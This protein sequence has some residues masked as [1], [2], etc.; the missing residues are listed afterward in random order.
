[1]TMFHDLANAFPLITGEAFDELVEDIKTRGL[2]DPIVM[3]EGKILDGRNRWRASQHLGIPHTEVKLEDLMKK[4]GKDVDP[5]AFVWSRNA[6]RRQLSPSQRA[7]A[8]TKLLDA[9]RGGVRTDDET[10]AERAAAIAGVGKRSVL[11]AKRVVEKGVPAVVEAV[12]AGDLTLEPAEVIAA[13][14]PLTQERIMA[15]GAEEATK[16]VSIERARRKSTPRNPDNGPGRGHVGPKVTMTRQMEGSSAEG[17]KARTAFWAENIE[18]I[19]E[20]DSDL[21]DR[22]VEDLSAERRAI[23]QLLKSIRTARAAEKPAPAA[24]KIT[25]T[26]KSPAAK[27]AVAPKKTTEK[28]PAAPRKRA[29]RKT[30]AKKVAA[31]PEKNDQEK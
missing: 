1:M 30:A 3:Y 31:T 21:L 9:K 29:P 23:E 6:V 20:L 22:F 12:E 24:D 15:R 26:P 14:P 7:M 25:A 4:I 18:L 17:S 27:K 5:V 16:V 8:A 28:A 19:K 10:T 2:L 13:K 11:R